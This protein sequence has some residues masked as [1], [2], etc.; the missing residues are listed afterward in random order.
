MNACF[1]GFLAVRGN[2]AGGWLLCLYKHHLESWDKGIT[3]PGACCKSGHVLP[4]RLDT[5]DQVCRRNFSGFY[6]TPTVDLLSGAYMGV[7]TDD[8]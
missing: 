6:K 2:A 1:C 8:E 7:E 5:V 4:F 3:G